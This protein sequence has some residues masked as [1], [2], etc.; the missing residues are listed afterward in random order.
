MKDTIATENIDEYIKLEWLLFSFLSSESSFLSF[1]LSSI[2][3]LIPIITGK[4]PS[5]P[6]QAAGMT[7][8]KK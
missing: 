2:R 6:I 7:N 4:I 5:N 8:L 3:F 1:F